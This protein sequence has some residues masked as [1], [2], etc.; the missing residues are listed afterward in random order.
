MNWFTLSLISAL[1]F[2]I[3]PLFL[4]A[5][6]QTL[7]PQVVMAWYYSIVAIIMWIFVSITTKITTPTK[8]NIILLVIVSILAAIADLAIF[9]AYKLSSNAGYPRS[10][11]AFSII[12]A[13]LLSAIMYRQ[14]PSTLGIVGTTFIFIGVVLLSGLK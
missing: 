13:T 4:K 1:G 9:Y 3:I 12:I 11:Q 14:L 10:I 2:G 5:V 6:Q 8:E 7:P